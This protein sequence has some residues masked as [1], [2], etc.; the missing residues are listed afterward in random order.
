MQGTYQYA[1]RAISDLPLADRYDSRDPV[2]WNGAKVYPMHSQVVGTSPT[3]VS[4]ALRSCAPRIGVR[5]LGIGLSVDGGHVLLAGRQLRGV[6]V[7]SDAMSDGIDLQVCPTNAD[8]AIA[9]TPVWVD[10]TGRTV[11]WSGNYGMLITREQGHHVLHCSTGVGPPDFSELV[12][13][14]ATAATPRRP[15]PPAE[16][17][18]YREALYELGVAM[19]GRGEEE[20]ACQLWSQAATSGHLGAAYD[21]GVVRFRQRDLAEAE[22]WWRTAAEAGDTRAMSGLAT[23]LERLGRSTEARIWRA[24]LA[25]T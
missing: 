18:R 5:S 21:L 24:A 13:E 9:L 1:E 14:V 7:W 20:Q 10:E 8:A 12:V 2:T 19:H 22:Y 4:L 6:D 17:A 23:V 3:T 25:E 16:S 15:E 11:S